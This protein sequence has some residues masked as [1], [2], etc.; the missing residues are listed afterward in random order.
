MHR[1]LATVLTLLACGTA[2]AQT[3][4]LR[5]GFHVY[6]ADARGW[7][8][9]L[10]S[11]G[12]FES[13]EEQARVIVVPQN[14][15]SGPGEWLARMDDGAVLV[16]EGDSPL[17]RALGI[18]PGGRKVRVRRIRDSLDPGL[19]I[20]WESALRVPV[21]T[22]P[23]GARVFATDLT[24]QAPLLAGITRGHGA[25]LWLAT[26]LGPEGYEQYPYLPQAFADL[27]VRSPFES[28]RLWAFFD[29]AYRLHADPSA[30]AA[31]WRKAGVSAVQ[32]GAWNYFE[33]DEDA[34]RYLSNLI[35]AC[36]RHN[37]L[38]YAWLELPHVSENFW[39]EHPEWREKTARLRD[40]HVDWRLL[41]NLANPACYDAVRRGIG[42]MLARFDWD[43]VNLA[44]LYFDGIL[45]VQNLSEFTPMNDDMR[46][47][48]RQARGFDP[49][50]LF[51]GPRDPAKL[52]VFLDY[53]ADLVARLQ[54]RWIDDLEKM[55]ETKP[56][57][58]IVLTHVDDRF[59]TNMRDALGA[60]AARLLRQLDT[61]EITFII[62]DPATVWDLGPKRYAEIAR[63]Y[64]PLT[65]HHDRVGVDINVVERDRPVFPTQKQTGAELL[66]LFHV[67]SESFAQVAF[68]AEQTV[69]VLDLPFLSPAS[70]VVTQY[71]QRDGRIEVESPYG[72]GI[73]WNGPAR[74]DGA[75]WPVQDGAIVWLPPGRHVV[76]SAP[77]APAVAVLD[78]NATLRSARLLDGGIEL[79]Y[80]SRS[81]ALV[82]VN[83]KPAR[84]T[85]DGRQA[86]VEAT[87]AP[88]DTY[89]VGLP[90]GEHLVVIGFEAS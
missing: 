46:R 49:H 2:S 36:H 61:H 12:L 48:F 52:R 72:V 47:E 54:E 33:R 90:R 78:L 89:A 34:D 74:V 58:D 75:V 6:A 25:A 5:E 11:M 70:A 17:S 87:P 64:A 35:A 15:N 50:E 67:A 21:Y 32:V 37:V 85:I 45:G 9:L 20:K 63:R 69:G 4:P 41:M 23:A 76:E 56:E 18:R 79:A 44:E 71:R 77:A 40:A 8:Q 62:E 31:V 88:N 7:P 14:T 55:R 30:L 29:A 39:A 28:R 82:S 26:P 24:G 68:Y 38:V 86:L 83:R 80:S 13:P 59:D 22:L 66:Q 16:M 51:R 53:R 3:A 57:L 43:G 1:A 73:R 19:R 27:G 65:P 81:R 10:R 42:E 60:D 84:L